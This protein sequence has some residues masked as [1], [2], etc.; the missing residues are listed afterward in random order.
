MSATETD[1]KFLRT[2]IAVGE[3]RNQVAWG[4]NGFP[5]GIADTEE[6]LSNRET[7]LL[8]TLHAEVNALANAPF[9]V[10][11]LYVTHRPCTGC[12]VRVLAAR[13]VKRVV[14]VRDAV[15][16]ARWVTDPD[17]TKMLFA[18]AGIDLV[19]VEPWQF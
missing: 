11:T 7:K 18:E 5:P 10:H 12:A 13:T 4:Y 9:P 2:A 16:E 6:R 1:V 3:Q 17:Y 8:L 14:Y 19:A 15:F